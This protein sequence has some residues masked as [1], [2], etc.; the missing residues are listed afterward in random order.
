MNAPVPG[1]RSPLFD[2]L[3]TRPDDPHTARGDIIDFTAMF[4]TLWRARLRLSALTLAGTTL[5]LVWAL[6]VADPRYR[7]TAQIVMA[8]EPMSQPSFEAMVPGL[9]SSSVAVNTEVEILQSRTLLRK[10]VTSLGL[11]RM[12][13]FNPA[14]RPPGPIGQARLVLGAEEPA[15]AATPLA[16]TI[17][18]LE[19][20]L[21]IR[22]IPD[23]RVFEVTAESLDPATAARIANTLVEI[24]L[25]DQ[26]SL[27]Q[28]DASR[29]T[30]WLTARVAELRLEL[31]AADSRAKEFAANMEL[32]S[33]EQ[34][35]ALSAQLKDIRQR[36]ATR[37]TT[38]NEAQLRPL[39]QMEAD[40]SD[41]LDRQSQDMV[42][43]GQLKLE[44]E[45]SRAIYEHFL[46]R[47]KET[48]VQRGVQTADA[49]LLA[50]A[51]IPGEPASPRPVLAAALAGFLALFA[52]AAQCLVREAMAETLRSTEA[53]ED[54]AGYA[55]LGQI[56][57][58]RGLREGG[59]ADYLR[60]RP[61]SHAAEAMRHLRTALFH[62][63]GPA[64]QVLLVT[65]SAANE[66]KTSLARA[67]AHSLSGIGK[68]VL[69]IEADIRRR[70]L[71]RVR[72]D[73][74]RPGLLSVLDGK[75][76]LGKAIVR[77]ESLGIWILPGEAAQTNTADVLSSRQMDSLIKTARQDHDVIVID[78]PPVL[79]VPDTKLIGRSADAVLFAV[80]WDRTRKRQVRQALR[81][82][83]AMQIP[84]SGLVLTQIDAAAARRYGLEDEFASFARQGYYE[85]I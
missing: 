83:E 39:R 59:L 23:S 40:L 68:K 85:T 36:V 13:E 9:G 19:Q 66:G 22:N 27:K 75:C 4:A 56:P 15:I 8:P 64:P 79:A 63:G 14:L 11:D 29:A 6:L 48:A 28:D 20:T 34:L 51:E 76:S 17:D 45:A 12:A 16:E 33:P 5:G 38:G 58:I 55:V 47:M 54:A 50:V 82:L 25:R 84:V 52:A 18:T 65:S 7:A 3:R 71:R 31:E 32:V 74:A 60:K 43:L 46:A 69:L 73:P 61:G 57:K 21:A 78:T 67:L 1:L 81:A 77:N 44:A 80:A 24:Y 49:R 30:D 62:G 35:N 42:M 41:R 37:S 26:V 70:P 2:I 72:R 53:L 10:V